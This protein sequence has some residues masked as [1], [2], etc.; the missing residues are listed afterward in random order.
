M[1]VTS[2][3]NSTFHGNVHLELQVQV[4]PYLEDALCSICQIQQGPYFCREMTCFRYFCRSCWQ[5]HHCTDS[6]RSHKPLMRN[7]K[8]TPVNGFSAGPR[9]TK[10]N[11]QHLASPLQRLI[12][13]WNHV[14]H[15]CTNRARCSFF[16]LIL[17]FQSAWQAVVNL[18]YLE[19]RSIIM[20]GP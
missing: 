8:S 13:L 19:S 3:M 11:G 6:T 10:W 2:F 9:G 5:W 4:D 15:F 14:F 18:L 16:H 12:I 17:Y 7:S 1:A 20:A